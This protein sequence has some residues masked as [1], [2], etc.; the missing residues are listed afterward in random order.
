M[1][2][3][4]SVLLFAEVDLV[5]VDE[6]LGAVEELR[7]EFPNVCVIV[8]CRMNRVLQRVEAAIGRVKLLS[9]QLY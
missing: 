7:D 4:F 3:N 1:T 5:V 9:M 8:Q 2:D 6:K